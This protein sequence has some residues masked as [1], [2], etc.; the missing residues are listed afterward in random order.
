VLL[1]AQATRV[2][3]GMNTLPR[4]LV[5]ECLIVLV[6]TIPFLHSRERRVK[7][8]RVRPVCGRCMKSH[9]QCIGFG[10][11][12]RLIMK[13]ETQAVMQRF[14]KKTKLQPDTSALSTSDSCSTQSP[15]STAE[16]NPSR[17]SISEISDVSSVSNDS[18]PRKYQEFND[19]Q[20]FDDQQVP[21]VPRNQMT[22]VYEQN[23]V[24][25]YCCRET[26]NLRTLS[27][28][29]ADEKWV[30]LLPEMMSRSNALTSVIYANAATY[31]AKMSGATSTPRTAL[32]HYIAALREL[33]QDLYDPVR[34]A[35]DE[36]LFSIILLGVFDVY[37]L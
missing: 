32:N 19:P 15:P 12:N 17:R 35:S 28:I 14:G 20:E 5:S 18:L 4:S 6:L 36:T 1:V 3:H 24:A 25:L 21:P 27:W 33:Q 37:S 29:M 10:S 13:D 23:Q 30:D 31:L 7:C 34:Q 16:Y 11:S 22:P 26:V 9:K 8:D 2:Q